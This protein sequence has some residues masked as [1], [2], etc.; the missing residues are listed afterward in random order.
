MRTVNAFPRRFMQGVATGQFPDQCK[1]YRNDGYGRRLIGESRCAVHHRITPPDPADPAD[2]SAASIEFAEVHLDL[3]LPVMESDS[4]EVRGKRWTIG[5]GNFSE[6]FRTYNRAM[7]GRP[8]AATPQQWITI[9]R[10]DQGTDTWTALS[11]QLAHVAWQRSQ[12][13]RLGGVSIRQYGFIFAPED[14]ANLDIQQGDSFYYAGRD[15]LV[16]WVSPDPTER[17]EA[18]FWM[19]TGE[20]M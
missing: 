3:R 4:I 1:V 10:Y 20:G 12:P 2:A 13:D 18:I 19:N 16:Q 8:V 7:V 17:R 14:R 9:R 6:T 15:A 11:P 5:G